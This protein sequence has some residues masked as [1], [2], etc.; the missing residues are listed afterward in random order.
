MVHDQV[1][2][3]GNGHNN[4]PG[5]ATVVALAHYRLIQPQSAVLH[6]DRLYK[7]DDT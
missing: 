6:V 1:H 3:Q 4:T 7:D 5:G 2:M